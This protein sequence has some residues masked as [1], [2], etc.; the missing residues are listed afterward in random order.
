MN[1]TEI[2]EIAANIAT[3]LNDKH[4]AAVEII[5]NKLGSVYIDAENLNFTYIGDFGTDVR[6]IISNQ[7]C[8]N[9]LA[10]KLQCIAAVQIAYANTGGFVNTLILN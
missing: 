3:V 2:N 7:Q 6:R 8:H 10:K 1:M 5:S 4:C 9:E